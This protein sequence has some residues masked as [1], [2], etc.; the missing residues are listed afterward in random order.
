VKLR[1][2]KQVEKSAFET[3]TPASLIR[4]AGLTPK[5]RRGG[6]CVA[7]PGEDGQVKARNNGEEQKATECCVS[8]ELWAMGIMAQADMR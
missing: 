2:I 8:L 5:E 3:R 7:S 1:R 4:A 6:K